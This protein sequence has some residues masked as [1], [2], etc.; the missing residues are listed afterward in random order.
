MQTIYT[1]ELYMEGELERQTEQRRGTMKV[2]VKDEVNSVF[3]LDIPSTTLFH[4]LT[5]CLCLTQILP[6]L[7]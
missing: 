4:I 3:S 2:S 6:H 7:L 5:D 1:T